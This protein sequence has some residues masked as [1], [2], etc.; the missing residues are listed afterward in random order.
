MIAPPSYPKLVLIEGIPGAGKTSTA[1]FVA[2]WLRARGCAVRLH[3]EGDPDHPADF[4]A[5][6]CLSAE[7][8]AELCARFPQQ[9]AALESLARRSKSAR[10]E[11]LL[12]FA[13]L[14]NPPADL[15][16]ALMERDVYNLPEADFLRV[17]L[18]RWQEFAA[19]AQ[20]GQAV[21][22]FECCLLQNQLTTL[23]AVHDASLQRI[24]AQLESVAQAIAPL[25]PLAIY[26]DPPAVRDALLRVCAERPREWLDF[27]CAYTAGQ[28]WGKARGLSGLEGM[29]SFY[30]ARRELEHSL[31]PWLFPGGLWLDQAGQDW[32]GSLARVEARLA[33]AFG[34]AA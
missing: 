1:R 3:L 16:S 34:Q 26:L 30:E 22:V 4:E 9:Q 17:S 33:Q 24:A 2:D 27:V 32:P 21:Y 6:A 18:R 29:L 5:T 25:A 14:D 11:L 20:A 10:G 23:M 13:K 7:Q 8:F 15:R 28:A 12:C 31:F 19:A